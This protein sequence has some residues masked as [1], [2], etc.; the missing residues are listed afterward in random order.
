[1]SPVGA[2]RVMSRV[3]GGAS[4]QALSALI[5][6]LTAVAV[7]RSTGVA[8]FGELAVGSVIA[9]I[10]G[11][12]L[13]F[14]RSTLLVRLG[15]AGE[16]ATAP[17]AAAVIR[18]KLLLS[19]LLLA[20]LVASDLA[21]DGQ[22]SWHMPLFA[23]YGA[24]Y[25]TWQTLV[26]P[27]R[28]HGDLMV[29]ASCTLQER[30]V[31]LATILCA[32]R[33]IGPAAMPTGLALGAATVCLRMRAPRF[34]DEGDVWS[35]Q[36]FRHQARPYAIV[37]LTSDAQQLDVPLLG[38]LGS[39]SL[40]GLYG[41]ASRLIGPLGLVMNQASALLFA[42]A[43]RR[44]ADG[45]AAGRRHA[46]LTVVA[47][48]A[49]YLPIL[50]VVWWQSA[51]VVPWL[52]GHEFGV[53]ASVLNVLSL[54]ILMTVLV[55]PLTAWAQ[56]RGRGRV[57]AVSSASSLT[58]YLVVLAVGAH[59]ESLTAAAWAFPVMQLVNISILGGDIALRRCRG[60]WRD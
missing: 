6:G 53:S 13:D 54:G 17:L 3:L 11:D 14:G 18:S 44:D 26:A 4:L 48:L 28:S 23:G 30:V 15:A 55:G 16:V 36:R 8:A 43:A 49:A 7:A 38:A 41:A 58:V 24:L 20:V 29:V 47:L 56:A 52:L 45:G 34:G 31:A 5:S 10:G 25:T 46:V 12:V 27:Y 9:L 32:L 40:A 59:Q 1:M 35:V 57:A 39:A 37:S 21:M 33:F 42:R 50:A 51:R 22:F 60:A 2:R 19:P